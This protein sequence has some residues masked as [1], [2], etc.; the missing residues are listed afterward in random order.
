MV[1]VSVIKSYIA[2]KLRF[3]NNSQRTVFLSLNEL[4]SKERFF[5]L[6][7][8]TVVSKQPACK[9]WTISGVLPPSCDCH[10]CNLIISVDTPSAFDKYSGS[11]AFKPS[12]ID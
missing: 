6:Q 4:V 5:Q 8:K 10:H 12:S 1:G 7:L 3:L 9:H 11:S 2:T